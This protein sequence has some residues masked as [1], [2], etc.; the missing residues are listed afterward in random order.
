MRLVATTLLLC[1]IVGSARAE[2][3]AVTRGQK[4]LLG[5]AINPPVWT[6]TAYDNAWKYWGVQEK[7]DKYAQAF[8]DRYGLHPAPY[9]NGGMPMGLRQTSYLFQKSI[10]SDCVMCHGGSIMGKSYVGL[11]NASL[12][13]QSLYEEMNG[14][15]GRAPKTPFVFSNVRGTNEA[16]GMAVFL[17]AYRE[18]NLDLR[19]QPPLELGLHDDMCEDVP[20]WWLLKKKKTMYYTGGAHA[21]SVRSLM[22]FMMHPLNTGAAIRNDEANFRAIQ[23]YLLSI[24]AP[25]YPFAIDATK[26][27]AGK[28]LF[29]KHCARCHGTYGKDWTY[30]NRIVPIDEIG[31]DT[32]RY[33]G[34]EGKFGVY[35]NK[36]W[37]AQEEA[38]WFT[39]GHKATFTPG[40]QAPPLDGIWATAPYLHNG[41]VPTVYH[42]LNSQERPAVYTR[43]FKTGKED[44]DP[45]DLGWKFT[46]ERPADTKMTGLERRKI[47][48]TKLPGRGN[49]GHTYGDKLSDEERRAVIEYLKTL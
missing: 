34:V 47:Y 40:Y 44:Y 30:P 5:R 41:S 3:D 31:T 4:A 17:L 11:G 36:S 20:A 43:S 48:N 29:G 1:T 42:V 6:Q 28:E 8:M 49:Q 18:P 39:T 26:A 10:A 12:D 7:P 46:K 35:Y 23:A 32:A 38:G 15:D 45:I 19:R 2:D 25:K 37:F 9:E 27:A 33:Q 13:L 16:G 21:R 22:Q 14:A 24:E